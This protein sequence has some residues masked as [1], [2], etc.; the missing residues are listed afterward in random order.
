MGRKWLRVTAAV[1]VLCAHPAVVLRGYVP[2]VHAE[3]TR[4]ALKRVGGLSTRLEPPKQEEL[5]SG[6]SKT[7]FVNGGCTQLGRFTLPVRGY[8]DEWMHFDN[9]FDFEMIMSNF[10]RIRDLVEENLEHGFNDPFSYGMIIHAVEDFYSHSNYV[11]IYVEYR[12]KTGRSALIPPTLEE[13]LLGKV[14]RDAGFLGLLRKDLR[15]G[16]YPFNW[17][18]PRDTDH[19]W[20]FAFSRG[21]NED[22]YSR[23]L[24]HFSK[25]VAEKA[26]EWYLR[27]YLGDRT[28]RHEL[29]KIWGD[30]LGQHGPYRP[31]AALV[32]GRTETSLLEEASDANS[33]S[34]LEA[35]FYLGALGSKDSIP[36][37]SRLLAPDHTPDPAVRA[38]V[39]WSLGLLG[40][41]DAAAPLTQAL[42]DPNPDVRSSAAASL[43]LLV[44]ASGRT[45]L[46]HALE[47]PMPQ[48][49]AAAVEGLGR[50]G[51][52]LAFSALADRLNDSDES[53]VARA[54]WALGELQDPKAVP[55]LVRLLQEGKSSELR[56]QAALSLGRIGDLSSLEA[57]REVATKDA[58]DERTR[59]AATEAM[60][61]LHTP[62]IA[63]TL[64]GLLASSK[65]LLRIYSAFA[66][67]SSRSSFDQT[68]LT[69]MLHDPDPAIRRAA[70]M[71]MG[72]WPERFQH[73]LADA[74]SDKSQDPT[75]RVLAVTAIG[76]ESNPEVTT[77]LVALLSV[78]QPVE[79]QAAA[80]NALL[81]VGSDM[82][83][84][85]LEKFRKSQG[86]S[87][88]VRDSLESRSSANLKE[89]RPVPYLIG[90]SLK[91]A[92]A[93]LDEQG[94]IKGHI[95]Y[96]SGSFPAGK[97]L[98]Q[99]PV[100][101]ILLGAGAEVDFD[102]STGPPTG[103]TIRVPAVVGLDRRKAVEALDAAGLRH[104]VFGAYGCEPGDV[105][106]YQFPLAGHEAGPG[107][108]VFLYVG[109]Y[110]QKTHQ[111]EFE[112]PDFTSKSLEDALDLGRK[113][114]VFLFLSD[115]AEGHQPDGLI[116]SQDPEPGRHVP[117]GTWILVR[118]AQVCVRMISE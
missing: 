44:G 78:E 52:S 111:G 68:K 82:T 28:A 24:H 15:T 118:Y 12:K 67:C 92:E 102:V 113:S 7:D 25:Q 22:T 101:G 90:K 35:I 2:G 72:I 69:A 10:R 8:Y 79:V 100:W 56:I 115:G 47:D 9:E 21:L 61:M 5:V 70:I 66:L 83:V 54:T 99:F 93:A 53:V 95:L 37:L 48:V 94:L 50:Q 42:G 60:G 11:R 43:G 87:P 59:A 77:R 41:Q 96:Q 105:V 51:D 107:D 33:A 31:L 58:L 110:D 89:G 23:K 65:T 27:I 85:A 98:R 63:K 91:D 104:D 76:D 64:E 30:P 80:V 62:E 20:P 97:V 4:D 14:P 106:T 39:A 6:S 86:L 75:V 26:A 18:F 57:L 36:G 81:M 71:A 40:I 112:V 38:Q 45:A 19:G 49:R 116:C 1:V 32:G 117:C 108:F 17:V 29:R 74:A 13:V 103:K 34:R 88:Q 84:T 55:L 114:H 46:F 109:L 73:E 3:I 16:R